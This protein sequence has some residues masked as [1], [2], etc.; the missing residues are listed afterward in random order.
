MAVP[1]SPQPPA[2]AGKAVEDTIDG[3]LAR[4][5]ADR[6][7]AAAMD[8]QNGR[9]RLEASAASWAAR[10]AFLQQEVDGFD[11][12]RTLAEAE[13]KAGEYATRFAPPEDEEEAAET[14]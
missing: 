8:T 6:A 4:A 11:A 12:K 14:P 10:A 9:G 1:N 5:A 3:C 2:D 13:W 7:R